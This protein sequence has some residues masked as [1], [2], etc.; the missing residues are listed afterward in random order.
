MP[1][2][3]NPL[4]EIRLPFSKMTFSPDIPS[5]A[6][7]PN[8]YNE[9][10][11]VETDVR[12]LKSVFGDA[13]IL[14]SIPGTPIFVTGSYRQDGFFWFVVATTAGNWYASK[15]LTWTKINPNEGSTI[16]PAITGY[17]LTTNITE[18]WN[19]TVPVFNDTLG[20]PMF[21]PDEGS[22]APVM[23]RYGK[24]TELPFTAISYP[25]AG[26]VRITFDTAQATIPFDIGGYV[27]V[28]GATT[29]NFNANWKVTAS[30]TT[31]VEIACPLTGITLGTS[32][33]VNQSYV[34]NYLPTLWTSVRCGFVRMYSTPNVGSILVAGDITITETSGVVKRNSTTIQWSQSFGLNQMPA[35][36]EIDILQ[37]VAD[38]LEV[39]L[40]GPVQDAF[41]SNGQL[42]VCSYWDTVVL[43]PL[44]FTTTS[45]PILG[46]RLF[47]TGRGLLNPNCS[48]NT[49]RIVYGIDAR[50]IWMFD[51]SEFTG[52]GN[53]RVKN[54]F[55]DQIDPLYTDKIHMEVNTNKNQIEIYYPTTGSIVSSNLAAVAITGTGGQFSC[56]ATNIAIGQ[57][58]VVSGT[59]TGTGTITGYT[60][61]KSYFVIA[62]NGTTTFTLS[63]TLGGS[64]ITT[65]AGTTTGLTFAQTNRGVPNKMLSYRY[66]LD[67]WNPPRDVSNAI[68]SVES[69]VW[70]FD[71]GTSTWKNDPASRT[72]VYA[73][74][75]TGS[76]LVMK[77]QGTA[78]LTSTANP[79][80]NI[81]SVYR[82]DNIK[83]LQDYSGKMMVHRI[84]PEANNVDLR[85]VTIIPSTGSIDITIEGANSVGSASSSSI[86]ITVQ[87]DTDSPWAQINQ[88]S[89]RVSNVELSDVSNSDTW[90]CS[91]ITWQYTQTEDDR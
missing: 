39:P 12:G 55:F 24:K 51:G 3:K 20:N 64:A 59:L 63:A 35:T 47:N 78:F 68:F 10:S 5:T 53:Q 18:S 13:E 91:A 28:Q 54:Y 29:A 82:R 83:L 17:T 21:W 61:P 1:Q 33:T 16:Q 6:Q 43:S 2:L 36:W 71:A 9:G 73:Q 4:N 86:P 46:V 62:T 50:D 48:V 31:Y 49:D 56:T 19:G 14:A 88:N 45:A 65:T 80:G 37:N 89:F 11:N 74:G 41:P 70:Y 7:G 81:T 27:L 57:E 75:I 30:T 60:N 40:R 25:T 67:I 26:T 72:V 84:L 90:L 85:G 76:K 52:L 58:I 15:D 23:V 8:E 38:S 32:T 87:L 66:D 79:S 69:P 44:N 42:Y 22:G 34:W 77:D